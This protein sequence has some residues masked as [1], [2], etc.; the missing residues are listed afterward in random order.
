MISDLVLTLPVASVMYS[1]QEAHLPGKVII[2]VLM[3]FSIFA[4][5]IMFTKF[6]EVGRAKRLNRQ[7][8]AAF[9]AEKK[10]LD[11]FEQRVRVEGCVLYEIYLAAC[12]GLRS[13]ARGADNGDSV[14]GGNPGGMLS[15]TTTTTTT[16]EAITL[17]QMDYVKAVIERTVA[18]QGLKLEQGLVMLATAVS[19]GPFLGLLGTVWGVMDAFGEIAIQGNASLTTMAPGV[20]AAL[21]TTVT[22]L[23]VA[24]P[25]MFGYNWLVH[26]IRA[27]TVDMDNFASELAGA[28][29]REFVRE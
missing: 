19:G 9:R 14:G 26:T 22:G 11:L 5:T 8:L 4:W 25:S 20:S 3:V 7:F 28:M 12:K 27:M 6:G 24:I 1:F 23:L 13:Y 16:A 21:I 29:E 2:G 17:K 15:L 18:E 10:P